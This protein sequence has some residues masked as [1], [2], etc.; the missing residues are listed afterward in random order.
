MSI[1]SRFERCLWELCFFLVIATLGFAMPVASRSLLGSYHSIGFYLSA[2]WF[3]YWMT[4]WRRS[5]RQIA[6]SIGFGV[7]TALAKIR[8]AG[9]PFFW[10]VL[11]R[12]T[13]R[14]DIDGFVVHIDASPSDRAQIPRQLAAA[15]KALREVWPTRYARLARVAPAFIIDELRPLGPAAYM[16]G[17]NVI[18]LDAAWVLKTTPALVSALVVH[19]LSHAYTFAC[20]IDATVPFVETRCEIVA[21]KETFTY[22]RKLAAHG[23]RWEAAETYKLTQNGAK[24]WFWRRDGTRYRPEA[25]KQEA[26]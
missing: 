13:I 12:K 18:A 4:A 16:I 25:E 11:R 19:E 3:S 15:L 17:A 9:A 21:L 14:C 8:K 1:M 10:W 5:R 23:Y 20:G 6:V 24:R 7:R 26:A 22:G 2:L